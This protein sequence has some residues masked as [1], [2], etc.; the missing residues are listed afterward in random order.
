MISGL[1]VALAPICAL[2]GY[3]VYDIVKSARHIREM[4][5]QLKALSH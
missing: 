4:K 1:I 5:Q 3:M 2:G